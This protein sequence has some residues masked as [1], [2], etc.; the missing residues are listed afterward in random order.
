MADHL[1][2]RSGIAAGS[3]SFLE[4]TF[5]F[6]EHPRALPSRPQVAVRALDCN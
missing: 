4:R 6:F 2:D 5:T 3:V 1:M